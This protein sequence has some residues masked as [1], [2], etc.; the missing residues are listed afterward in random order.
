MSVA[1]QNLKNDPETG[2]GYIAAL[3]MRM[4][5]L[6]IH[7]GDTAAAALDHRQG[8]DCPYDALCD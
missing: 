2:W 5:A 6:L 4:R 3:R 8:E 1:A 7:D